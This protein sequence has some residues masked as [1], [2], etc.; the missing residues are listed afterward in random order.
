[1]SNAH[2]DRVSTSRP[3]GSETGGS[4][5]STK[6]TVLLVALLLGSTTIN[7]IDRQVLSVLAPT[8]RDEFGLSNTGYAAILN[9]FMITYAAALPLAGW[10]IVSVC[11]RIL[12]VLFNFQSVSILSLESF[13]NV[14]LP[15]VIG[16]ITL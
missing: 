1:M 10:V 14:L 9:A 5:L 11:S 4:T 6:S 15:A 16:F 3:A 2:S 12:L 7:Y 8:L 13:T